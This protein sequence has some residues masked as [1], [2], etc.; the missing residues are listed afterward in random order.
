MEFR[1]ILVPVF[2]TELPIFG[3]ELHRETIALACRLL[4]KKNKGKIYAV[5]IIPVKRTLPLDADVSAEIQKAE[6]VLA[7]VEA[8]AEQYDGRL[9]SDLVQAREIAPAIIECAL[10]KQADL[11]LLGEPLR[12]RF[13]QFCLG[14]VAPYVLE[15]A[16]CP[17]ILY[18]KPQA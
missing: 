7:E 14:N 8:A 12:R 17:V 5:Y 15:N 9:E 3:T 16:P 1:K 2:G 18:H 4:D 11:V 10:D 6:R 13:G